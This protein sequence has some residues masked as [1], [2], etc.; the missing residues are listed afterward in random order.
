M[1]NTSTQYGKLKKVIVGNELNFNKRLFDITMKN[2][3]KE[4][5][6]Q[7]LYDSPIT[8]YSINYKIL[9]E[10]IE[11]LDTL[12]STLINLGIDVSRP[13]KV[14]KM[15]RIETPY[16][17]SEG[18]SASNVRDL[19]FIYN[20]TIIE[21]PVFI[22]NRYFENLQLY[23]ILNKNFF[24]TPERFNPKWIKSPNNFLTESRIDLD[25]WDSPRNFE[26]LN[27][28]IDTYDMAIDAAQFIKI[29]D[30]ECFVNIS[31]YNHYLG[32][33]WV[34]SN[35]PNI[36]FYPLYQLI[37]NHLDGA[38]NILSDGVFLVN[39]AY[40]N[41]KEKLPKKF[42]N[43][44]Y[45]IPK[46]TI[47]KYPTNVT[48]IDKLFAS[49]RGMDINVLSISP[50]QVIVSKDA[51]ETIKILEKNNFEAIPIQLRHSEIFAGGIHCSTLDI[52][53]DS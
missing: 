16:F 19:T 24:E 35:F 9:Q 7:Q 10:R 11:D 47:R 33:L 42:K 23:S 17:K 30:K 22:R 8:E 4:N 38:F 32:F 29:N 51:T 28:I 36:T 13:T 49:E 37:D 25:N 52:E 14:D 39:P 46:E 50:K 31:T 12:S 27:P 1:I 21:T 18:S 20:N 41:L 40:R 53:R 3:Y 45:L 44:K 2:F 15:H 26:N 48:D 34:K 6:G 43:W 5:L